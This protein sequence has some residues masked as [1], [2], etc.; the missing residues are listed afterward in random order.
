[1]R[2]FWG[3]PGLRYRGI[4]GA[5][6]VVRILLVIWSK[7]YLRFLNL[8]LC[9]WVFLCFLFFLWDMLMFFLFFSFF[10]VF[11]CFFVT[12]VYVL[13]F[14]FLFFSSRRLFVSILSLQTA[15]P[16]FTNDGFTLEILTFLK[17]SRFIF[18]DGFESV[19]GLS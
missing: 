7:F 9:F 16:T 10:L 1:M 13:V 8:F 6:K 3:S 18:K 15:S 4:L 5:K 11:W 2:A 14:L 17:K 12:Y 19:L